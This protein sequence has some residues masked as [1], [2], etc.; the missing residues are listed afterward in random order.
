MAEKKVPVLIVEDVEE[1]R[2]LLEEVVKKIPR[3]SVSGLA[4]NTWEARLEVNRRRPELILLDEVLPG[5]SSYDLL[6]EVL[7]AGIQVILI[8]GVEDPTHSVPKG[9]LGRLMKPTWESFE[10]DCERMER[11]IFDLLTGH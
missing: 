6:E 8:T 3:L 5:E 11:E 1:M 4:S 10:R 2:S 7:S 9:V